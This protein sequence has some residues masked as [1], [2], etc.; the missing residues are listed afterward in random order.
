M[1]KKYV[2]YYKDYADKEKKYTI[3]DDLKKIRE[4]YNYNVFLN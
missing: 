4:T 2:V 1:L 3:T